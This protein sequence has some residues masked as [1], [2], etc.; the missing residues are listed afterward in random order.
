MQQTKPLVENVCK[1][2]QVFTTFYKNEGTVSQNSG[3]LFGHTTPAVY[4]FAKRSAQKPH[5]NLAVPQERLGDV[6]PHSLC[7]QNDRRM[8]ALFKVGSPAVERVLGKICYF[9]CICY[10][11]KND[12]VQSRLHLSPLLQ[13]RFVLYL[14]HSDHHGERS[15]YNPANA[16]LLCSRVLSLF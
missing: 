10:A 12:V 8:L 2:C 1:F 4:A 6:L 7:R 13:S 3:I 9:I 16:H 11:V 14:V 15:N 5:G